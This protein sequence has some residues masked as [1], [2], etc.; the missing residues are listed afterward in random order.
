LLDFHT[1]TAVAESENTWRIRAVVQNTGWLPTYVTK[2]ALATKAVRG[3]RLEL[4]LAEGSRLLSGK[5]THDVG[6][7][8]GRAYKPSAPTRRPADPTDDRAK[9][10]WIVVAPVGATIELVA[11]HPRAG[12]VRRGLTLG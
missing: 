11:S 2:H 10:E 4:E 9:V 12:T 5:A 7:L 1:L 6:Q 8:E 3:V